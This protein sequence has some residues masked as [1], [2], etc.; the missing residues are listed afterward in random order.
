[1]N[2]QEL[3]YRVLKILEDQP[4][5]TQRQ[6]AKALGVSLGKAHYVLRS[7]IDVGWIKLCNFQR[8]SNKWGYS[9]LLTPI[10]VAEK[11]AITMS[12]LKRKKKEYIDLKIEIAQ[13]QQ[14]IQQLH[15]TQN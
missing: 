12:F 5:L 1:M 7:L 3:K 6:L 10:G 2:N 15:S 13:L 4:N 8:S 9:Y 11:T 14:E